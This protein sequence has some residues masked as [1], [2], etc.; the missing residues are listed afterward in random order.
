MRL[1]GP[2]AI[3]SALALGAGPGAVALSPSSQP[4]VFVELQV[5]ATDSGGA[6]VPGLTAA[7]FEVVSDGERR[8]VEQFSDADHPVAATLLVDV[9][10][11]CWLQPPTIRRSLE[12]SFIAHVPLSDRV[13]F[14]IF[15]GIPFTSSGPAAG[16]P[17]AL[18][19]AAIFDGLPDAF[20]GVPTRALR[21][22]G[23]F[24]M[25]DRRALLRFGPS[26]I[27][28]AI[29]TA[30]SPLGEAS[31]TR[32]AIILL[33]DGR[34]TGN[35]HGPD[36][37]LTKAL[38]SAVSVNVIAE[39][40][41][42]VIEQGDGRAARVRPGASLAWLAENTGG[43]YA[44]IDLP[45]MGINSGRGVEREL[46]RLL[47]RAYADLHHAYTIGFRP[48]RADGR[49]HGVEVRVKRPG[50]TTRNRRVYLAPTL[51]PDPDPGV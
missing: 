33:T 22:D 40:G 35:V 36:E 51:P 1:I 14:A 26:P 47:V 15:G 41:P 48:G 12:S 24:A 21:V 2:A 45:A 43:G 19:A 32:R 23:V 29:D 27:W 28:D 37:V 8:P 5:I 25:P 46:G 18:L 11:S 13:R 20:E 16:G 6:S 38:M 31:E 44:S 42:S 50:V 10:R 4:G 9:S 7:D 39:A 3:V 30:V 49:W 34:A 17:A